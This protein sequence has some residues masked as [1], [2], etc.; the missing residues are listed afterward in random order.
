[1]SRPFKTVDYEAARELTVCLGDCLP[2]DCLAC[3]V[4]GS[5]ALLNLGSVWSP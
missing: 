3:F 5:V 1:M 2:H 4:V